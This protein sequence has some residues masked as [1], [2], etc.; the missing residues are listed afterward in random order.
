MSKNDESLN[1]YQ[2]LFPIGEVVDRLTILLLKLE[3][4][5]GLEGNS[6]FFLRK[7][8]N[9]AYKLVF[10]ALL[11]ATSNNYC[12]ATTRTFLELFIQLM[13]SNSLQWEHE[14]RVREEQTASAAVDARTQ[15][16]TRVKIRD[17]IDS[18]LTGR[19]NSI[20]SYQKTKEMSIE[21]E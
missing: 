9:D 7:Q 19:Q 18:L 15:N 4:I 12:A 13:D 16:A 5:E 11:E 1:S 3:R 2:N 20:Y 14:T 17:M 6:K 8:I 10:N 21:N